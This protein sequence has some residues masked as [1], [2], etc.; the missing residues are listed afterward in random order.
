MKQNVITAKQLKK[1]WNAVV[2]ETHTLNQVLKSFG[3]IT[4]KKLPELEGLTV[5]EF[6]AANGISVQKGRVTVNAIKSA[7]HESM[8]VK[9]VDA[10]GQNADKMAVFRAVPVVWEALEGDA[11]Y[12]EKG[13]NMYRTCTKEE[14]ENY[15]STGEYE[16]LTVYKLVA[17][18]DYAWDTKVIARAMAQKA[19]FDKHSERAKNSEKEFNELTELY[20]T[21][22]VEVQK[23]I[24]ER[25]MR[26]IAKSEVKF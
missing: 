4:T 24:F 10:K 7:W 15:V 20:V 12:S 14:A 9:G 26:K 13:D 18:G 21:Y 6:L 25:K 2:A 23:G 22:Q 17:V 19:Q 16:A 3:G 5:G 8:I 1:G 11:L